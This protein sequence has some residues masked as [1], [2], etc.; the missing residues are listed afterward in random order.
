MQGQDSDRVAAKSQ[1][2][3]VTDDEIREK[4][5]ERAIRELNTFAH[6]LRAC[7]SCPRGQMCRCSAPATRRRTS[8]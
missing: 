5:L 6:D 3:P 4:Y 1:P 8:C 2:M 7:E